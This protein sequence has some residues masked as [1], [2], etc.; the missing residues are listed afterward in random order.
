VLE[1]LD[2]AEFLAMADIFEHETLPSRELKSCTSAW[3][4]R[5]HAGCTE[6]LFKHFAEG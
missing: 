6:A 5:R 2:A 3:G 1:T 4:R